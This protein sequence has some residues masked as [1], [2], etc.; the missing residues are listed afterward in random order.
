[1]TDVKKG[2]DKKNSAKSN[3]I[4]NPYNNGNGSLHEINQSGN[5]EIILGVVGD[6]T[7]NDLKNTF[8]AGAIPL[9]ANFADL[10]DLAEAGRKG[11]GFDNGSD[12][13]GP[14]LALASGVLKVQAQTDKGIDVTAAGIAVIPDNTAGGV[15]VTSAG[16]GVIT[17]TST[18]ISVGAAGVALNYDYGLTINTA[19]E[20]RVVNTTT[21]GTDFPL[22]PVDG[23]IHYRFMEDLWI[24]QLD[25]LN[26]GLDTFSGSP[27]LSYV[28]A[29]ADGDNFI[30]VFNNGL[31]SI[32]RDKGRT[33]SG[34]RVSV[35]YSEMPNGLD[36]AKYAFN[37]NIAICGIQAH[38]SSPCNGIISFNEGY[39]W[40]YMATVGDGV[41]A[42]GLHAVAVCGSRIFASDGVL[43]YS[44]IDGGITFVEDTLW[45]AG[46]S[47][48]APA[49][50]AT[51]GRLIFSVSVSGHC[52]VSLDGGYTWNP[53]TQVDSALLDRFDYAAIDTDGNFALLGYRSTGGGG[54]YVIY[55]ADR[56]SSW[57]DS[58]FS[59]RNPSPLQGLSVY[60]NKF[61]CSHDVNGFGYT[62]FESTDGGVNWDYI[63]PTE[64]TNLSLITGT[65]LTGDALLVIDE[66]GK[67]FTTHNEKYVYYNGAWRLSS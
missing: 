50:I 48:T 43:C 18:G 6:T 19:N 39:S 14:G 8:I 62:I 49:V 1:M 56:G 30:A 55:S 37:N 57:A 53:A 46:L 35:P 36:P 25:G 24:E 33:W 45:Y 58:I 44:S 16:L 61:I 7:A 9:E 15:E 31:T 34:M 65:A 5:D 40:R 52:G 2:K 59:K 21:Q 23:D 42:T 17:D 27:T 26:S 51:S 10:I 41:A 47:S 22:S 60:G 3:G 13:S 54:Y 64:F 67:A 66:D 11:V 29:M 32:S 63:S 38:S 4:K 28:T 20:L 12:A